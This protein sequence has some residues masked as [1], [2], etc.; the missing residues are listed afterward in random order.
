[1]IQYDTSADESI[2]IS[3]S[4]EVWSAIRKTALAESL[5]KKHKFHKDTGRIEYE[6]CSL[7]E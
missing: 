6:K 1:M 4:F 2:C 3:K 7:D 5:I